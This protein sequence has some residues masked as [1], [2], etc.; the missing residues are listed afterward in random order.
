VAQLIDRAGAS[1]ASIY[2]DLAVLR[3]A[4]VPIDKAQVSGEMRHLLA[5]D[6]AVVDRAA[7]PLQVAALLTARRSLS[8]LQGTRLVREFDA[9]LRELKGRPQVAAQVHLPTS[10]ALAPDRLSTI[11]R[12]M[13]RGKCV[14][15]RY[16]G[17]NDS[18]ASWRNVEP[19]ELRVSAEQPYLVAYDRKQERYKTYK[20]AR[21]SHTRLLDERAIALAGYKPEIEFA[22]SRGIWS[23]EVFEVL[24]RLRRDVARFATEWPLNRV[25]SVEAM[26]NGD[27]LVR[28]RVA[29]LVEPLRW[30]MRWGMKAEVLQPTQLRDMVIA[31]FSGGLDVYGARK[32]GRKRGVS[33]VE[34]G[35][36]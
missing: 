32:V 5:R 34:T 23:G 3:D 8:P 13:D 28:A 35:A 31:E 7:T 25:Q 21:L 29:G 12:A 4:G 24:V 2:R 22:H 27:V 10:Q 9:L 14:R 11:D 33:S 19:V 17:A 18:A 36:G 15:I 30:V 16:R 6:G 20:L 1:R 26:V